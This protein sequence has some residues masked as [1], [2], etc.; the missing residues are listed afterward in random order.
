VV[1]ALDNDDTLWLVTPA[2]LAG[3][4]VF[5]ASNEDGGGRNESSQ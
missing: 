2:L 1:V 4:R 5:G 3:I